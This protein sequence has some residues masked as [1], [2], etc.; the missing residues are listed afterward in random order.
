MASRVQSKMKEEFPEL[1]Y[2]GAFGARFD[3]YAVGRWAS[4]IRKL[5]P[6]PIDEDGK[7][8]R[9]RTTDRYELILLAVN[10]LYKV[11][12]YRIGDPVVVSP[13]VLNEIAFTF[14]LDSDCS[15]K[16]I[17]IA[18]KMTSVIAKRDTYAGMAI[19]LKEPYS[20]ERI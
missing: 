7:K 17:D 10:Y 2:T 20:I 1:D 14:F 9:K 15:M 8:L 6:S 5:I 4:Y 13:D 12:N 19:V 3:H 18:S 11:R 16:L